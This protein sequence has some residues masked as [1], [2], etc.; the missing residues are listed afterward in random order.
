MTAKEAKYN[1][2]KLHTCAQ[3]LHSRAH[4][5]VYLYR[6]TTEQVTKTVLEPSG[7]PVPN[8]Y[9]AGFATGIEPMVILVPKY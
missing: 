4:N 7:V 2:V 3:F 9:G 6:A 8:S 1:F 5:W